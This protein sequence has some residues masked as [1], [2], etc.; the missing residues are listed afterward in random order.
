MR[1]P[2]VL[3][4]VGHR[5]VA[6]VLRAGAERT[7]DRLLLVF[8]DLAGGVQEFT[9]KDVL[10]RST[11]IATALTGA[12]VSP[13]DYVHL[14]LPNR[15]EF[16]FHWFGCALRGAVMVPTN[17]AS[18]VAELE[19]ILDHVGAVLSV[20]DCDGGD[21]VRAARDAAGL[22]GEVW[23]CE[24]DLPSPPNGHPTEAAICDGDALSD[25]A[26]MYTSGTTSRPK[27]V[28]VTHANYVFAGESVAAGLGLGPEDRFLVVLPL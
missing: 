16:I 6:D 8:D 27:G 17:V 26:V 2:D 19:Y 18:S 3:T 9:W 11:S 15:P 20:T 12:G 4:V 25:L 13:G 1:D 22:G 24:A 14:H 21:T 23:Q 7:P 10:E 5:T 28:R